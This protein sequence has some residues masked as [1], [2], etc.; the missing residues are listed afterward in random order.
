MT[1]IGLGMKPKDFIYLGSIINGEDSS[2][3]ITIDVAGLAKDVR[4]HGGLKNAVRILKES[5]GHLKQQV[6]TTRNQLY[7]IQQEKD[8]V[9]AVLESSKKQFVV[10]MNEL[11]KNTIETV[12]DTTSSLTRQIIGVFAARKDQSIVSHLGS[13]YA[14]LVSAE[15]GDKEV[16]GKKLR[17][18][19]IQALKTLLPH[20]K[21]EKDSGTRTAITK[22]V[23]ML[24][25]EWDRSNRPSSL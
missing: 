11:Q 13:V 25:K 23:K 9:Q 12:K 14:P 22:C 20:L 21:E 17:P 7:W 2:Y 10:Y 5:E 1:L 24:E 16:D 6:E 19:V 15:Y 3:N 4:E 18:P 8:K